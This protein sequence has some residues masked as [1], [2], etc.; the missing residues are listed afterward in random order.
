[1]QAQTAVGSTSATQTATV[2][3]TT[4]GTLSKIAV[5]TQGATGLD[6]QAV[7]NGAATPCTTGTAYN[8]ND[9]CTVQY[10]F[11]PTRPWIRYGGISLSDA[12]GVLLGNIYLTGTGTGPQLSYPPSASTVPIT[13]TGGTNS[14]PDSVALDGNGNVYF[15]DASSNSLKEIVAVGGVIP[16]TPAVSTVATGFNSPHGVAVDGSGNLFVLDTNSG[17]VKEIVAVG[18]VI[19]GSPTPITVASGFSSPLGIAVDGGGNIY[20]ADTGNTALKEVLAV[21][22]VI[23]ASPTINT[24]DPA[25]SVTAVTVDGA[26]NVFY[27][28]GSTQV[29]ELVGGAGAPVAVVTLPGVASLAID[30]SGDLYAGDNT[31]K[32]VYELVAVG[33]VIPAS[34]TPVTLVSGFAGQRGVAVDGS[35]NV[36]VADFAGSAGSVKEINVSAPPTITF[37]STPANTTSSDSPM[38]LTIGN[39]GTDPLVFTTQ[40]ASTGFILNGASTC[41][42]DSVAAGLTCTDFH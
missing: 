20:V 42:G 2:T 8:V 1:M 23:P 33:G 40:V 26:G 22:G 12:S 27:T 4:A 29:D 6:Y 9:T 24:L 32:A 39:N 18:G 16:A 31:N 28:A 41:P 36:Y 13:L 17:T 7:V 30:G 37:T 19:P 11:S 10:T 34:P 15:A 21:N 38:I 25:V 3:I 35:G 14:S 5:L